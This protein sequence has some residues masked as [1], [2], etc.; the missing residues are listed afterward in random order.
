[1]IK[2]LWKQIVLAFSDR[3]IMF[4]ANTGAKYR[5]SSELK[6]MIELVDIIYHNI[7]VR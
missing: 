5:T 2:K 6:A 7:K 4:G 1:M 3:V